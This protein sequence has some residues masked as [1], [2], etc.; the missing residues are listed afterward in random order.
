MEL[1]NFLFTLAPPVFLAGFWMFTRFVSRHLPAER[2]FGWRLFS[3]GGFATIAGLAVAVYAA[4]I[5]AGAAIFMMGAI[6]SAVGLGK[7]FMR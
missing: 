6:L 2:L 1:K 5:E 7:F 3:V 4:Q